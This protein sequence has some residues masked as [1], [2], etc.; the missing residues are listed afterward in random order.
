MEPWPSSWL[1]GAHY[2]SEEPLPRC[3]PSDSNFGPLRLRS[4]PSKP[5]SWHNR[6]RYDK[7]ILTCAW[8]LT[9]RKLFY[10]STRNQTNKNECTIDQELLKPPHYMPGRR[11]VRTH[12][13]AALFCVKWRHGRHL[14]IVTSN[15]KSDSVNRCV[16]F[17]CKNT[18]GKFHPDPIWN[19]GALGFFEEVDQT[20][21]TTRRVA[22]ILISR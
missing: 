8:K 12:Q 6:I 16:I 5:I 22:L 3:R 20:R 4:A 7:T 17:T 19:D 2:P 18:P 13:M 9:C 15:R 21:T 11:F 10:S 1:E 14:E